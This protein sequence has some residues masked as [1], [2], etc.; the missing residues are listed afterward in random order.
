MFYNHNNVLK[1]WKKKYKI[2]KVGSY[3]KIYINF[4]MSK[5][6]YS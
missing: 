4:C 5:Y 3:I 1:K 2:E 6:E